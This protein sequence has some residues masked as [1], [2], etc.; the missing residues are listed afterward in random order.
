MTIHPLHRMCVCVCVCVCVCDSVCVHACV[1]PFFLDVHM[2]ASVSSYIYVHLLHRT[3]PGSVHAWARVHGCDS[4]IDPCTQRGGGCAPRG[5]G[6]MD[7]CGNQNKDRWR[8]LRRPVSHRER[9]RDGGGTGR[10]FKM[11]G[12]LIQFSSSESAQRKRGK[13]VG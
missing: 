4:L 3:A 6:C 8:A 2:P 1:Y 7:M 13:T 5:L 11:K 12:A 10:K 9:E